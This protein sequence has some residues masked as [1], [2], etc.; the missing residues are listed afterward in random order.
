Q[1]NDLVFAKEQRMYQAEGIEWKYIDYPDNAPCLHLLEDKPTGMWS[2]LDEEGMLPKGSNEGWIG[3]LYSQYL[4]TILHPSFDGDHAASTSVKSRRRQSE[5]V[6]PKG[7]LQLDKSSDRP[8]QATNHQRVECQFVISHF[9]GNVMYDK[10]MYLE[11]NQDTMPA[12]AVELCGASTNAIVQALLSKKPPVAAQRLTRQPSNLR[13]ASVSSQFKAQLDELIV[14]IGRTQA[15]FIR[16]IKSNDAGVPTVLDAPR[17]L[18]Q[19]RSGGVLE[20]VRIARAGYAV[21]VDHAKFLDAFGFFLRLQRLPSQ[22]K[23]TRTTAS[24]SSGVGPHKAAKSQD[25]K[26]LVE[27]TAAAVLVQFHRAS[28]SSS[29]TISDDVV[30]VAKKV[31]EQGKVG[32]R[33]AFLAS[34]GAVGFQI[35]QSKVFFRKDVYND[36]RRFRLVTRHGYITMIQ[37]HIRGHLARQ[38]AA[39]MK[40]AVRCLQMW[41]RERLAHRARRRRG[42]TVLQSWARQI[43]A[44]IQYKKAVAGVPRIQKWWR[45]RRWTRLFHQ[46][47]LDAAKEAK[48]MARHSLPP[49]QVTSPA[50]SSQQVVHEVVVEAPAPCPLPPATA[51]AAPIKVMPPDASCRPDEVPPR[52]EVD[53]LMV[54]LSVENAQLKQQVQQL[55]IQQQHQPSVAAPVAADPSVEFAMVHIRALASQLVELQLQ[56]AM[57]QS[58]VDSSCPSGANLVLPSPEAMESPVVAL[59]L[60]LPPPPTSLTE[61]H[62]QLQSLVAKIQVASFTLDQLERQKQRQLKLQ[63]QEAQARAVV[64]TLTPVVATVRHVASYVPVVSYVV[65]QVE[66]KVHVSQQSWCV[67]IQTSQAVL[68]SVSAMASSL[69]LLG[70]SNDDGKATAQT[71]SQQRPKQRPLHGDDDHHWDDLME[72]NLDQALQIKQL[73]ATLHDLRAKHHD[74]QLQHLGTQMATMQAT[75]GR[76]DADKLKRMEDDLAYTSACVNQL[77]TAMLARGISPPYHA[78]DNPFDS[79]RQDQQLP[80]LFRR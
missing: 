52:R 57:I 76:A 78:K 28:W 50:Q 10:D 5:P 79:T 41:M 4:D 38:Q 67:L 16:C 45:H 71:V 33:P 46:R 1:F 60:A 25:L 30:A 32:D 14:V 2:L 7:C 35:G 43:L 11:K 73:T 44:V 22:L 18:Q 51:A 74:L 47:I 54:S 3:K 37:Q 77:A 56:C 64:Q 8:F 48:S 27:W 17:V 20:A 23:K 62:G 40:E 29:G 6:P 19:L 42:A 34:C 12:E 75:I 13:S 31:V 63:A 49:V 58:S 59:D 55:Q 15:R 9:A 26:P 68:A 65:S 21:R 24:L 72:C 36:L 80:A 66:T 69:W 39:R 53:S 70:R 61:A